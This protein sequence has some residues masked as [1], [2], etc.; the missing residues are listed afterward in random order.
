[1]RALW[2]QGRTAEASRVFDD[3]RRRLAEELGIEPSPELRMLHTEVLSG[4]PRPPSPASSGPRPSTEPRTGAAPSVPTPPS[5]FIGRGDLVSRVVARLRE[6]RLV[7]LIGPGGVGKTRVA[8]EVGRQVEAT[9]TAVWL[10]ELASAS[11]DTVDVVVAETLG[12]EERAGVSLRGRITEVLGPDHGL[13]VLDNCEH[14][15]DAAAPLAEAVLRRCA[16]VRVLVTS[17]E[18]LAVEGEHLSPVS[19]FS[20]PELASTSDPAL[21]LFA[22]RASAVRSDFALDETNLTVAA[23]ICRRL[24]GLPLAIELA[25]ARLQ[26]M[27]LTEVADGLDHRFRL[28]TSGTRT[29]PRQRSLSAA[30]AWSYDLLDDEMQRAFDALGVFSGPF[31][32]AAG[33]TVAALEDES[34][35]VAL[36]ERSL[37][38]R[39]ADGRYVLLETLKDFALE[40]LAETGRIDELRKRHAAR[41]RD[42]HRKRGARPHGLGRRPLRH[43]R[44]PHRAPRRASVPRGDGRRGH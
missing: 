9:G 14:V 18:R 15:L 4:G 31:S 42:A 7:T 16:D 28:L 8:L 40:R 44:P 21:Q 41:A 17:R 3:F 23:E 43:R 27:E 32:A 11:L 20:V 39:T 26:A 24:D 22:D 5:S 19:P 34:M 12:I 29:A 36:V 33:I 10:C 13:L 1:M 35:L 30:V 25:A 37:V 38:Q 6:Q 2:A